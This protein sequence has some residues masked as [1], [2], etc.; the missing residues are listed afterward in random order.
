[1]RSQAAAGYVRV[2]QHAGEEMVAE[3]ISLSDTLEA[4]SVGQLLEN[5]PEH[6]RGP[7]CLLGGRTLAGRAVHVVCTTARPM[8]V[9]IT[10]YEPLPPKWVTP[11]QRGFGS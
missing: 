9:I 7:C 11:T 10:V 1:M 6:R 2:T 8:L 4:I 5:Y 3:S